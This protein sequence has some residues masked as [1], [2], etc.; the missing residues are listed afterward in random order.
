MA[1]RPLQ[2]QNWYERFVES[3]GPNFRIEINNP[4]M[5]LGGSDVYKMYG[6]THNE[7]LKSSIGF[8]EAGMLKI[9]SDRSIEMV[10]GETASPKGIDI[11]IQSRKGNIEIDANRNG[12]VRISGKGI[13]IESIG[14]LTLASSG[15]DV[16]INGNRINLNP[17]IGADI[18]GLDGDLVPVEK[19]LLMRVFSGI[20]IGGVGVDV[21]MAAL[22]LF[23]K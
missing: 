22:G 2:K 23:R 9:N 20:T 11:F 12:S 8:D 18:Q 5:G 19:Q 17:K 16:N 21:L 1:E 10:A 4:T 14:D 6:I 15:G 3:Y 7:S 13:I